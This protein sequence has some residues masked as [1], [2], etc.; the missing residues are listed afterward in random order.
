MGIGYI[1]AGV[2]F[3]FNPMISILDVLPDFIGYLLILAGIYK[4]ADMT[5]KMENIHKNLLYLIGISL[6]RTILSV[7]ITTSDKILVLIFVFVFAVF[8]TIFMIN[9]FNKIFDGIEDIGIRFNGTAT[10][11]KISELRTLTYIFI[12]IRNLF[13]VIPEFRHLSTSEYE[14][15]ISSYEMTGLIDYSTILIAMNIIIV[16]AIGAIW[17]FMMLSY[18]NK[19]RKDTD[20]I[21]KI[22]NYFTNN[23]LTDTN[24]YLVRRIAIS[25]FLFMLGFIFIVD[26]FFDNIDILPDFIGSLFI[27]SAV[28]ILRKDNLKIKKLLYLSVAYIPLSLINWIYRMIFSGNEYRV[29]SLLDTNV[30]MFYLGLIFISF[31]TS[32]ILIFIFINIWKMFNEIINSL[33]GFKYEVQF[34]TLIQRQ[35]ELIKTKKKSNIGILI[36]SLVLAASKVFQT[37]SIL[38]LPEYWMIHFILGVIWIFRIYLFIIYLYEDVKYRLDVGVE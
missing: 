8:E 10:F 32:V 13:T 2:V 16:T 37:A 7:V 14:G 17:L 20:F 19:I 38:I 18:L 12:I 24:R 15:V 21:E 28:V 35:N 22:N 6:L 31:L 3:L 23:I 30:L 36:I 25:M 9:V 1:I 29:K 4:L 34:K 26:I 33:I 27:F 5:N 11:N